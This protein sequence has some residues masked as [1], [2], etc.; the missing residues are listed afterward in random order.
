MA[1]Q[2]QGTVD[3]PMLSGT[4]HETNSDHSHYHSV[5]GSKPVNNMVMSAGGTNP[6]GQYSTHQSS[7]PIIQ[8]TIKPMPFAKTNI[9][10]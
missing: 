2:P 5:S 10:T 4:A 7:H 8:Y 9:G 1:T 3:H 6:M